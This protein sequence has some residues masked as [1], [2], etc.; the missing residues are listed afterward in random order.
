MFFKMSLEVKMKKK[1]KII[2]AA[3]LV[4]IVLQ[5]IG[6]VLFVTFD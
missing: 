1:E 2:I 5:F 3:L 6:I 4:Y